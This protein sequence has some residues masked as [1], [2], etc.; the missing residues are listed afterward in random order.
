[1]NQDKLI[2]SLN[3][4]IKKLSEMKAILSTQLAAQQEETN[5]AKQILKEAINE[6]ERIETSKK[7][8]LEDWQNTLNDIQE[9]DKNLSKLKDFNQEEEM[10]IL[11]LQSEIQGANREQLNEVESSDSYQ[12][13]I[14]KG[15]LETEKLKMNKD[16]LENEL[17]RLDLKVRMLK[18]SINFKEQEKYKMDIELKEINT[19][20]VIMEASIVKKQRDIDSMN[21]ENDTNKNL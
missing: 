2:D 1:M 6:K 17:K 8:I 7:S 15:T 10:K 14:D 5:N 21:A 16:T 20:Q 4:Q 11:T 9:R 19:Q 18:E 12:K 13:T 3:E